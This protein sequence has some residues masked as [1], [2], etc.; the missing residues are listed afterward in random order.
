MVTT[1]LPSQVTTQQEPHTAPQPETRPAERIEFRLALVCYGGV[2]LA[3]YMHGVTKELHKLVRASRRFD[4]VGH[5]DE[6]NPFGTD[7]TEW[8]YFEALRELA[9]AGRRLSVAVDVIAGTS[10]GGINGVVLGKVLALD[11]AQESLKDVWIEEGDLRKLL[12]SLPLGG[13]RTRAVLAAARLLRSGLFGKLGRED[14]APSP[15]RGE[16]MSTLLLRAITDI[17]GTATQGGTLLP[18]NGSLELYV[19]L[20]DLHGFEVLV[21][22]GAGGASQRDRQHAQVLRFV[23]AHG[24]TGDFGKDASPDL[25]FAARATSSFPGAFAP[26]R[27]DKFAEECKKR[28]FP[29]TLSDRF[30][31]PYDEGDAKAADAWFVDGGVLDNAPFDLVVAAI[32]RKRAETEVLRRLVYI[33]PDPGRPLVPATPDGPPPGPPSWL[34]G[35]SKAVLGVKGTHGVLRDLIAL[36]DLNRKIGEVGAIAKSQM[37]AVQD[38]VRDELDLL[39]PPPDDESGSAGN[40]HAAVQQLSDAV[41]VRAREHLGAG[42]PTYCRLKVEAAARRMADEIAQ[43]FVFPPDSSRTSF[44]R[45]AIG[46]W[47]R[48]RPEW[49][50]P[51]PTTLM[52]FL[53]PADIPYRERRLMFLLAGVNALYD[54][55]GAG[56]HAPLR[57][58]LDTLKTAAWDLL[59]E[60]RRIPGE[61]VSDVP[62]EAVAFLA[63]AELDDSLLADPR[64]FA[65]THGNDF[66]TLFRAY[67]DALEAALGDGSTPLWE[68]FQRT[69]Q[70]WGADY[71]R[72]L[73]SRYLAFPFWDGLIFPTVSLAELP[74]FTPI[75]VAQFSP[76]AAAALPTPDG[77]KLKGVSLHHFGGFAKA[78]WRENDYLWGRLDGVELILRQLYDAGSPAPTA[79]ATAPPPSTAG[80]V[81]SAGGPVLKA[82]LRAVLDSEQGLQ[83]IAAR[84]AE[85]A[86]EVAQLPG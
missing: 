65:E 10:A 35:V 22:T 69:T 1:Q 36:R 56:P 23:A 20:T 11:G 59:E 61:V 77:G 6:P 83:R 49:A 45:A 52:T 74:Q 7:E 3:V 71:R 63:P 51:D 42:F 37:D 62:A 24:D 28:P 70:A 58:D 68:I 57:H 46:E 76:L 43:R 84:R 31:Y 27:M 39:W 32:S 38:L 19:T 13:V 4:G 79:A 54:E 53:R 50:D 8:A 12:R 72:A 48:G 15:L 67:R 30:V 9:R 78:E 41:H 26:I 2:S 29:D 16:L 80:A 75:G 33:E 86:E 18:P 73:L 21:P 44:L 14:D 60:L 34:G 85:L 82:G 5:L 17:D 55:I 25:A 66:T 64:V 47:A 81:S 40:G